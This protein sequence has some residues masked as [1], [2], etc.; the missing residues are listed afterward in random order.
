MVPVLFASRVHISLALIA[1]FV[2]LTGAYVV[3]L[4]GRCGVDEGAA[5]APAPLGDARSAA[6]APTE[7]VRHSDM[8]LLPQPITSFGAAVHDGWLYVLGGYAG[9]PHG[10][11]REGQSGA[12][13]RVRVTDPA[14]GAASAGDAVWEDLPGVE[15]LQGVAL[16]AYR[17]VLVRVGGMRARNLQGQP[18]D[19]ISTAEAAL[20]RPATATWAPLPP[21]PE[22]R[23]SHDA[24]VL[25]GTLYVLGGWRLPGHG[26]DA[27]WPRDGLAL[28][29]HGPRADASWG[30]FSVPFARRALAVVAA[31]GRL[32]AIGGMTADGEMSRRV[33]IYDPATDTWTRG[34]DYPQPGFGIAA[35]AVGD[36]VYASGMD[37]TVYRLTVG[38]ARWRPVAPLAFAR[39]FH[40]LHVVDG[41]LL[42]I[43]GILGM[44]RE[45]RVRAIERVPLAPGARAAR[46]SRFT[47]AAPGPA[48]NRQGI[49]LHGHTLYAFGGNRSLDQ[50]DFDRDSFLAEG[51]RLHL[52]ALTWTP[53]APLPVRRQTVQTAVAPAAGLGLA[54]GGFGHDG[55]V[56]RSFADG[57]A[58]DFAHDW[59]QA[60]P[61]RLPAP[62]SQFGLA[63]Y[64]DHLWVFGGLDYD[65]KRPEDD[66]FRHPLSVLTAPL[67]D[68]QAAW[69]DAGVALPQPRRAFGGAVLGDR[70]YL[71]GGMREGFELVTTCDVYDFETG[72]WSRI[73]APR[74]TRLSPQ[75]VALNGKL[76]LAGGSS[77]GDDGELRPDPSV[78]VFDPERERWSV[79]I[80]ELPLVTQHMRMLPYGHALLLYSAHSPEDE[81]HLLVVE[82]G[83]PI[84]E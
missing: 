53:M 62:R 28:P 82:P 12:L 64:R 55:A 49:F 6:V 35:A 8:M 83:G 10:Y 22:A 56:A 51:Y 19:L 30:R 9:Q 17:E 21:L 29:L 40:R 13:R 50:H 42:A 61:S 65:P 69:R 74:R 1:A 41:E 34:P 43:G 75:L 63:S 31:G 46:V 2:G 66:Q 25:D 39:F 76:Y 48:K 24:A 15:P 18:E 78:E 4:H 77:L 72:Q 70:Y 5:V 80:D 38:A 33:D 54:I 84:V 27:T 57:F 44:Q 81:V 14:T 20:Y 68:P 79:L 11:S 73:P 23:S 7:L 71:V 36:E 26:G 67:A 37:G 47:L 16:V 60:R 32:L 52:G 59:W 45:S 3:G 58:Y